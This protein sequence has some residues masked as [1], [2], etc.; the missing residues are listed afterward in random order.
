MCQVCVIYGVVYCAPACDGRI[1]I[2][3][4]S[5]SLGAE[6]REFFKYFTRYKRRWSNV[7]IFGR[8]ICVGLVCASCMCLHGFDM[9]LRGF[10]MALRGFACVF[11]LFCLAVRSQPSLSSTRARRRRVTRSRREGRRRL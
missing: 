5:R 9:A 4:G 2:K 6:N 10:C 8:A 3:Q 1:T 11:A 7:Y